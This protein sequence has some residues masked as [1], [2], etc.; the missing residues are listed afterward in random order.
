MGKTLGL[1][2]EQCLAKRRLRTSVCVS[3]GFDSWLEAQRLLKVRANHYL[4]GNTRA[5]DA[6]VVYKMNQREFEGS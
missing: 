5:S 3:V 1:L 2:Q 6:R 4:S